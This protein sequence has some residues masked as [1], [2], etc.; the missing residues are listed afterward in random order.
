MRC[1]LVLICLGSLCAA[2]SLAQDTAELL[3]RMKAMEARIQ[4]LEA[5]VQSLK[6]KPEPKQ[7][8]ITVSTAPQEKSAEP[9]PGAA[10]Q[11]PGGGVLP[12][13]GVATA[14]SK[15]FNPDIAAIG[16]FRGAAGFAGPQ[17]TP[18]LE[19]QE[20]EVSL[21]A[22]VDPYARADFFFS[23]GK[24]GVDLEEGYLTF[25]A[26]PGRLQVKA[27]KMRAAYGKVNT[28]HLHM[29][30]WIDRPLMTQ[31]L[32]NGEEGISDAGLS[33]SR[34]IPAPGQIF[35]EA[36]GQLFRGDSGDLF[37]PR[38]R[39]D[40]GSVA[41]LR[42]FRDISE[43]TNVDLGAS[44]ARGHSPL[45][46][47]LV[48]YLYGFDATVRW[49]PLRRAI[50]HSFIARTE[51]N[52]GHGWGGPGAGAPFPRVI[53]GV[54]STSPPVVPPP[55]ASRPFGYYVSGDYQFGRRWI[56]GGR[57]DR[58]DRLADSTLRDTGGSILLTYRPS[59]FSQVRGQFRRTRYAENITANEFLFQFQF[60]IGAHGAHPF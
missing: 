1:S 45:G 51:V 38:R 8:A 40:V 24:E 55:F 13:Y 19:M 47:D 34:T 46:P 9:M 28:L 42:A 5:E 60:S 4:T 2:S 41:H 18:S 44:F 32:L 11:T 6:A 3:A 50:Y 26:L 35:L 16:T 54:I 36:T 49:K 15:I 52:W 7:E 21:Q 23:F 31:N 33:L 48:N 12:Y 30:P 25:S 43:S 29:V 59:E 27:G 17:A 20:A 39:S 56:A 14:S 37:Q 53:V 10:V 22:I 58:S 57:F